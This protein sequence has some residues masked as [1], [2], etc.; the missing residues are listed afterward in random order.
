MHEIFEPYKRA[1]AASGPILVRHVF[2]LVNAIIFAVVALL[3]IFGEKQAAVF[4]GVI[5]VFNI[6]LGVIQDFRARVALE[7]LELMTALRLVRLNDDGTEDRVLAEAIKVHDHVRLR[8]G[9]QIPCDGVL[10]TANGF[11][12][13]EALITG[14]SDSFPRAK[15]ENVLAGSIV[16][17][18]ES[19]LRVE[20]LFSESRIAQMTAGIK[21]Y[22]ASP[23]PIQQAIDKIIRY[24]GYVLLGVLAFAILRGFY[25]SEP[26]VQIIKNA[27][28]LA[29]V[30]VPQGLVVVTTLL[31]AFGA[32]S[33]SSRHVLFQE[34]NA[35][36]K[37]GR[38][39]NLC[40]DKTGTLTDNKLAV[41]H[42]V[43][44]PDASREDA[45]ELM[46]AYIRG[47]GDASPT[48]QAAERFLGRTYVGDIG[49]ALPFSSWRQY[50][51][52]LLNDM[53]A[54]FA[55]TAVV[56]GSPDVFLTHVAE[57]KEKEW[58][59]KLVAVHSKEGKRVLCLARL[60]TGTLSRELSGAKL[61]VVAAFIFYS[62]L[63]E[64]INS[65]IKF[66]QARGVRIRILTGDNTETARAVAFA[67]GVSDTDK[68]ITGRAMESWSVEDY[69][70]NVSSYT[71][72]ARLVPEQKVKIIEALRGDGF[73]AMVGDGAND[74]LAIKRS[75]LGIAMFD[76]APATRQLA[77]VVL[78]NN[79]FT[80][81]PGGVRLADNFIRNI[82]IFTS[83][84]LNGS[85]L[86]FFF[87][88]LISMFGYAYP[89]TPLNFTLI[90]YFSVGLP[91]VL[92]TYWAIR[93]AKN[94]PPT[95]TEQFLQRILPF[96]VFASVVEA[97]AVMIVFLVSP[98]YLKV[99]ESNTLVLFAFVA[100]CFVFFAFAP[101]V[102]GGVTT[103]A[104]KINIVLLGM[105]EVMLL[106]FV[107]RIPFLVHF[108]DITLPFPAP[109]N[110][111]AMLVVVACSVL[112][113]Y[114]LTQQIFF[115]KRGNEL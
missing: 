53:R 80:A 89:L 31:F 7:K 92:I 29:S 17:S 12:V 81:L 78:M 48:M 28:A 111:H 85:L 110:I 22:A 71:I 87:F 112:V 95:S 99:A 33:Y 91:G 15:G 102:Y 36:E 70:A 13:S 14:E 34:I 65:A 16:T 104:Q 93:S 54:K 27:G 44:Y 75:D 56:V 86:G 47:S 9:D 77:A 57:A 59:E 108:F 24:S 52:V 84:F 68:V 61:S 58:L 113:L 2:L 3:F 105:F 20:K 66:F 5:I 43:V 49:K 115:K 25:V 46:A 18:G 79:S 72:F 32:A 101:K 83:I 40:M 21:R 10:V 62:T 109:V 63:R 50:G 4:L 8:V 42:L 35:T 30:I 100:L 11:E 1:L 97:I 103:S 90:N 107:L 106:W 6:L 26:M 96:P 76:G 45:E 60:E 94:I 67:A 55:K 41:Q 39:K 51:A 69:L 19:V 23:S 74:A 88:I 114:F 98:T 64:G 38:I 37:L 73:T 82:E